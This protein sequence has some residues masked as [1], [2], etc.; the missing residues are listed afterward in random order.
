MIARLAVVLGPVVISIPDGGRIGEPRL[1]GRRII[2][3]FCHF[4]FS[5]GLFHCLYCVLDAVVFEKKGLI[6]MN[7]Y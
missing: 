1:A 3:V 5:F 6:H 4:V 7:L 2:A